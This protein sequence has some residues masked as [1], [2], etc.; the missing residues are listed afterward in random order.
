MA[1]K[2]ITISKSNFMIGLACPTLL[3]CTFNAPEKL[4]EIDEATQA[5]F[6]QGHE[7]GALAK[8]V[9]SNG[10]EVPHG[11]ESAKQTKELLVKRM[12]IF[13]ATFFHK[14]AVCKVDILAPIGRD[15]W[16]LIEVKSSSHI[17]PEHIPDVAF[18]K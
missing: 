18:Q 17:K 11:R 1:S 8:K 2:Q 15:E 4:P 12:P 13:E 6:D 5:I 16:D 9:Y 10:T 7:V 3:W 14:N